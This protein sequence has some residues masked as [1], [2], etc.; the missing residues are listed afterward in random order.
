MKKIIAVLTLVVCTTIL[1]TSC[2]L[3]GS[4]NGSNSK[5]L[6]GTWVANDAFNQKLEILTEELRFNHRRFSYTVEGDVIH[7]EETFPNQSIIGDI[8]YRLDGD[9]LTIKFEDEIEGYFYGRTG[10]VYLERK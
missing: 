6:I 10:T 5:K 3:R 7:I 8:S 2:G 9:S 1:I 4:Y